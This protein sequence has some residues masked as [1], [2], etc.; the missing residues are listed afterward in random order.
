VWPSSSRRG[1]SVLGRGQCGS[2]I[3]YLPSGDW[4]MGKEAV[5]QGVVIIS[6]AAPGTMHIPVSALLAVKNGAII[7]ACTPK[8]RRSKFI[9]RNVL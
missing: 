3:C 8:Q 4:E 9:I 7:Q 6:Q 5:I 2:T 1:R